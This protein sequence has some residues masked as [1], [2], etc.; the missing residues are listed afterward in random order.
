V[1]FRS[2]TVLAGAFISGGLLLSSYGLWIP[3]KAALAQI[4]L[5]RAWQQARGGGGRPRPWPWADTYPVARLTVPRLGVSRI[6]LQGTSGRSLAFGPGHAPGSAA[7]GADGTCV[8]AAHRDTSFAFLRD[9]AD[10]EEILVDTPD[11]RVAYTVVDRFVADAADLAALPVD[12][13]PLLV[14]VTCWPFDAVTPGGPER[15][16]VVAQRL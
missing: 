3:A 1:K 5:E 8:V 6:V 9:L 4:L 13:P 15:Y 16:V 2:T 14:L 10:G 7:P 12:G 11:R